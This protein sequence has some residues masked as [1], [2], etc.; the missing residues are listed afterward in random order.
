[1]FF[2]INMKYVPQNYSDVVGI[3]S[4]NFSFRFFCVCMC[5][6]VVGLHSGEPT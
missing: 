4:I 1:M 2:P 3:K 6:F 5:V